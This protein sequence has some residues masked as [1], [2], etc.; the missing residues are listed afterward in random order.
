MSLSKHRDLLRAAVGLA[1]LAPLVGASA[2]QGAI[3]GA[4]RPSMS[5]LPVLQ[6]ATISGSS[7]TVVAFCFDKAF[8]AGTSNTVASQFTLG[9]YA[10]TTTIRA[11]SIQQGTGNCLN[12]FFNNSD[13]GQ[14]TIASVAANTVTG[15]GGG[16]QGNLAD[17]VPLTAP[18][19][20]GTSNAGTRGTTASPDLAGVTPA[21]GTQN[22]YVFTFNKNV[23]PPSN[24]AGSFY[25]VT[26]SGQEAY[27]QAASL[28]SG[29][30][31]AVAVTFSSVTTPPSGGTAQPTANAFLA[32]VLPSG[33]SRFGAASTTT[34]AVTATYDPARGNVLESAVISRSPASS[35]S[36]AY[37]TAATINCSTN[38][39]TYT[40]SQAIPIQAGTSG[41]SSFLAE[42]ANGQILNGQYIQSTNSPASQIVVSF[43][44][45]GGTGD[46]T[47][48]GY[49]STQCEHGVIAAVN[50]GGAGLSGVVDSSAPIGGNA[51]AFANAFTSAPDVTG[52][53]VGY[54]NNANGDS[55]TIRLDDRLNN[56]YSNTSS[57]APPTY[58]GLSTGRFVYLNGTGGALTPAPTPNACYTPNSTAGA[59]PA[60]VQIGSPGNTGQQNPPGA[61]T[62]TCVYGVGALGSVTSVQFLPG[63]FVGTVTAPGTAQGSATATGTDAFSVV[64]IDLQISSSAII[65]AYRANVVKIAKAKRAKRHPKRARPI[66]H[67]RKH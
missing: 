58:N 5:N 40:L 35:T 51:G 26:T 19:G 7:P 6:S 10:A 67:A 32:G 52:I 28:V 64:Q 1:A 63:A 30:S 47:G 45:P 25:L 11:Q 60:N 17:S 54:E 37:L 18:G 2:A 41:A 48:T 46:T 12:A 16:N 62:I 50:Q 34:P 4:P 65:K 38:S 24:S 13:L 59:S 53:S 20:Q 36:G 39:I 29:S 9:G 22:T 21:Q 31:N 44:G 8:L 55:L 42:L 66:K 14:Y 61:Q 57:G 33:A 15:S 49:L 3:G 27:G 56:G 23:T 43:G